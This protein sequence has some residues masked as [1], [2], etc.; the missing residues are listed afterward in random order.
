[1]SDKIKPI[2]GRDQIETRDD[3]IAHIEESRN[4]LIG[5]AA[6][7]FNHLGYDF[8]TLGVK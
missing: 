8:E 3:L 6:K 4:K 2:L 1:M 5:I 7:I